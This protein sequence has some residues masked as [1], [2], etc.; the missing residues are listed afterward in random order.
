MK[1]FPDSI[2]HMQV[3]TTLLHTPTNTHGCSYGLI[4]PACFVAHLSEDER[5]SFPELTQIPPATF[6]LLILPL[7]SRGG[8]LLAQP[9]GCRSRAHSLA[10]VIP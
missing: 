3:L 4:L 7:P 2:F 10:I 9:V 1:I 8:R 6:D 5:E